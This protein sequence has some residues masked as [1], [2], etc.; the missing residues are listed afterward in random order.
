MIKG[1]YAATSGM[2]AEAT[3]TDIIANNLANVNTTGYKKDI[4]VSKDFA[5]T[6]IQRINDGQEAPV[7]GS[8]GMGVVIDEVKPVQSQ[9][10][11]HQTGNALDVAIEGKG[12]FVV[13]TPNG[14]RY[15]RNGSFTKNS[16]GQL[17][18]QEGYAVLGN[19][20]NPIQINGNKVAIT[21]EGKVIVDDITTNNLQ[22]VEFAS[23]KIIDKEGSSLYFAPEGAT[24]RNATGG[25][26]EGY[27]EMSNV[28]VV[29][30]MVNLIANYRAY[31]VNAKT[32]QAHDTL[33]QKAVNEVGKV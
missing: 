1:I 19:N 4:A 7:I 26:R 3:R 6:L 17:V 5:S 2:I 27:L 18:T 32:V 14:I 31:E 28:N 15:T 22:F 33:L 21:R 10:A 25:I 24:I 8:M 30:E 29:L 9:G 12:Y 20:N 13:Q 16:R 23:E 11:V